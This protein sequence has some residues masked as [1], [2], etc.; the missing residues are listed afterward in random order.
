M[1]IDEQY[2]QQMEES[3]RQSE[4]EKAQMNRTMASTMFSSDEN[5]NLV[6][7]QLDIKE[8]LERIEHLLRK[9]IP[10][11]DK[12]G[13]EYFINPT[14]ENQLFNEHGVNF[15]L[16]LLGWYLNKNI[17]LSNFDQEQ[18]DQRVHQFSKELSN[19]IH[20]NYEKMGLDNHDKQKE[21]NMIIMNLVN[22]IEAAYNRALHGGE[23]ESL[24]TARTVHQNEA[25]MQRGMPTNM[26]FP[27]QKK[28]FIK[29]NNLV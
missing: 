3:I 10:K 2:L 26:S 9:H 14:K 7:W 13:N 16:N 29:T 5:E 21:V 24:R 6:K 8:E 23:R 1:E 12:N 25:M 15:I 19:Y 17:I 27:A 22:T 18:I 11:R 20:N 28:K 4:L